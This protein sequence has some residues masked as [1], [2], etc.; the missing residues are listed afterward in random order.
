M[1]MIKPGETDMLTI[2][3]IAEIEPVRAGNPHLVEYR[4]Q[5]CERRCTL[6]GKA[7]AITGAA[8]PFA[9]VRY[10]DNGLGCEF[11]WPTVERILAGSKNFKS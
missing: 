11:A 10:L 6:D 9:T 3:S 7:A 1:M 4:R 8:R 5:L 2:T